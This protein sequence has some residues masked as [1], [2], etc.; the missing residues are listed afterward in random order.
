M[1]SLQ[2][3]QSDSNYN[4]ALNNYYKLK[5]EYEKKYNAKKS[6]ILNNNVLSIKEKKKEINSFK[7][8]CVNCQ[9]DGG[10]IF[11]Y[12][13]KNLIALCGVTNNPCNLNISIKKS[14]VINI[15][16]LLD[17]LELTIENTKVDIIK[18][19]LNFLFNYNNQEISLQLF[20]KYKEE[21]ENINVQ[22]NDIFIKYMDIINNEERKS[23]VNEN[24]LMQNK[25]IEKIKL[26]NK[27]FNNTKSFFLI[28]DIV[29]IY[30]NELTK[31]N[32]ILINLKYEYNSVES[33]NSEIKNIE[34][35]K[36]FQEKN[37]FTDF[38]II[39]EKSKINSYK[40]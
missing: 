1:T 16:S 36:L 14:K 32:D 13:D 15:K 38:E 4:D 17:S 12:Q 20:Q 25:I 19:K 34:N 30:I 24:L 22:Y 29:E 28:S 9:R 26:L 3:S 8:K 2:E 10:T 11:K 23:K 7:K 33:I 27:E 31:L 5:N 18:V 6:K 21:L 35:Y 37:K 40:K 39:L